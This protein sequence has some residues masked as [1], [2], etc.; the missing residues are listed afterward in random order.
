MTDVFSELV[1]CRKWIEAALEYAGGTHTFDDI[2]AG[3][4][5]KRFQ[6]WPNANS[7]VIT[8]VVVYPQLKDLH[9]FLAGG[10]LDELKQMRPYI[11]KW[12]RQVGCTRVS[13]AGRKG[14]AK[15]FLQDEGYTP[16]WYVMSKELKDGNDS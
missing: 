3:V 14:W 11:E 5:T 2:A 7:A 10:D 6:L 13:L 4:L 15:T 1:R 8:E 9:Y 12:G 16:N